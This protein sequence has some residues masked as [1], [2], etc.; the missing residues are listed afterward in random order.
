MGEKNSNNM[1]ASGEYIRLNPTLDVEDTQ[2]KLT[3]TFPFIDKWLREI[4]STRVKVLDVGGGA[5]LFLKGVSGYLTAKNIRVEQYA[6]DLSREML[7][8]QKRNNPDI[9]EIFE[10]SIEKTSFEDKKI[11]LVF[12]IDVLE[13]VPDAVKALKELSRISKYVIF[14]VPLE[15]N[16]Y[17]NFLNLIK[18]G[19]LRRDITEKVGHINFYNFKELKKQIA[20]HTGEILRY[21]FTNVFEYYLSK[22]YYK[23]IVA[24]EKILYTLGKLAFA[25]SPG[26][27][28][29]LFNDFVVCLVKCK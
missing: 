10:G 28:S 25:I 13:H 3:K 24:K 26:L 27:C 2:W 5:G 14:K 1:Y 17:Y 7:E 6:L 4:P 8:I 15:N 21:Y 20:T 18:T 22:D 11:D 16:L 19:G 12:M 29:H 9:K 23:R